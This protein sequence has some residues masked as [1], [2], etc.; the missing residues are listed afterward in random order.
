M[1]AQK[2]L[3]KL[4]KKS[5]VC[6]KKNFAKD[7][8]YGFERF[9]K[10]LAAKGVWIW[11]SLRIRYR[12]GSKTCFNKSGQK[13]GLGQYIYQKH[14]Q[15]SWWNHG[16]L[17][18]SC[19]EHS[20]YIC[21]TKIKERISSVDRVPVGVLIGILERKKLNANIDLGGQYVDFT[22]GG[23]SVWVGL[24]SDRSIY[25][26]QSEELGDEKIRIK[27]ERHFLSVIIRG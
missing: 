15:G 13:V 25:Q 19:K 16:D 21:Q 10:G 5:T 22:T 18:R 3:Q 8:E 26:N 2:E 7:V 11:W 17:P 12:G 6:K 20:W 1:R 4:I 9:L 27:L 14:N 23:R 24:K